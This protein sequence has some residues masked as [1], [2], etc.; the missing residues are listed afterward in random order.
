MIDVLLGARPPAPALMRWLHSLPALA[1]SLTLVGCGDDDG[2]GGGGTGGSGGGASACPDGQVLVDDVCEVPSTCPE[3]F[4][5][6]PDGVGC[7]PLL[8]ADACPPGTMAKIGSETCQPVGATTCAAGFEPA[9]SGWGCAAVAA[10]GCVGATMAVLGQTTCV[11]IGDCAGTFPPAAATLFVDDSYAP[12][13]LD[14]TH[15]LT[16]AEAIQAAPT[17]ATI[18]V[19][20]GSYAESLLVTKDVAIVG[21]CAEQVE[22]VGLGGAGV[23]V[24]VRGADVTL[25]G[26]AVRSHQPGIVGANGASLTVRD[27]LVESNR[28]V[29]VAS[30]DSGTTVTVVD[31]AVRD[32]L[33]VGGNLGWGAIAQFDAA[34]VV[35]GSDISGHTMIGVG[36]LDPNTH[37]T[38]RRSV[39]RD[40]RILPAN[41]LGAAVHVQLG[42]IALV[43]DSAL[44]DNTGY[45]L[46][47]FADNAEPSS[48]LE[49]TG[50]VI[51]GVEAGS[52]GGGHGLFLGSYADV[53]IR[54]STFSDNTLVA[55]SV[56][57]P[58]TVALS[59]TTVVHTLPNA[60]FGVPLGV[61]LGAQLTAERSAFVD[62][63]YYGLFLADAGSAATL[64]DSLISGVR[65][66]PIDGVANGIDLRDGTTL[67]T[68]GT[69]IEAA[70]ASG[71]MI[72]SRDGSQPSQATLT[73]TLV[74]D[75]GDAG[76]FH[77]FGGRSTIDRSAVLRA[78][79]VALY[80]S[81]SVG[82]DGQ[83]S[84]C[85]AADSTFA[86]TQPHSSG[87]LGTGVVS[88]ATLSLTRSTVHENLG[89]GVLVAS[90]G[91][92]TRL[93]NTI[94]RSTALETSTLLYAHGVVAIDGARL[95]L[96]GGHILQ[97]QGIGVTYERS[98]G[99]LHGT[100]IT[101]NNIGLH[102]QAGTQLAEQGEAPT[103]VAPLQLVVTGYTTF[104]DNA[105]R[106]GSEE[107]GLPPLPSL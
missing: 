50:S 71:L 98:S 106:F 81:D 62:S 55:L 13:D 31:S 38:V 96:F 17:T 76:I 58:G 91:S 10:T 85:T 100:T 5:T 60:G 36:V 99:I 57:G 51:S 102:V 29:G 79:Q 54:G 30:T 75:V 78:T 92:L 24:E 104:A 74:Q 47:T 68:V 94:V 77:R 53:V 35:D 97:N 82:A 63:Q 61:Q 2:V 11:D 20:A 3:G 80:L 34:L 84:D 103:D 59:D 105:V 49:V 93:E 52:S 4:V 28:E 86:F 67:T 90:E 44:L 73:T 23:G 45:A 1:L 72:D 43:E 9:A 16:I 27:C 25:E 7:E 107:V 56:N 64:T 22:L 42:G 66:D 8:P 12:G 6:L 33:T 46:S 101:N 48:T 39:V 95:D 88:G 89:F 70:E 37:L 15:F 40:T 14:A 65:K 18:A 83:R 21:R 87:E 41:G 26:I 32:S 19:E 69:T